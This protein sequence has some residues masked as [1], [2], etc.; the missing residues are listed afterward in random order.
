MNPITYINDN[1][2]D[3]LEADN[4]TH[5]HVVMIA[6]KPDIIKQVPVYKALVK[7]GHLALLIHT[8]QHY[9]HN[10]SGGMLEEFG[11][12]PDIHLHVKGSQ[13]EVIA[14]IIE[15]LGDIFSKC[16]ELGKIVIPYVHGD[17]TTAMAS[18]IAG[19]TQGFAA[20]HI[21]A[22]IR[23]LTPKYEQFNVGELY[24]K[25]PQPDIAQW[26]E[27]LQQ[28]GNWSRGSNEPVPEQFNTK[29]AEA[30]SG[31]HLAS[32]PLI[33]EFLEAEGVPSNRIAVV[34][35]SVADATMDAV[36]N[37]A[38]ST[39]FETY[40]QLADGE[41][42]RFCIHR[43]ENCYNEAR[44]R[45]LFDALKL[46]VKQGRTVLLINM[47]Q[48]KLAF[49]RY[50]LLNELEKLDKEHDNFILS[51]VWP[52]YSDVMAA[53]QRAA[54]CAT[55]SGSMQE[56]MNVLGIPCVT[57]R[58]GSDRSEAAMVGGNLIAPPINAQFIADCITYAWDNKE[59]RN[60]EKI[61]GTNVSEKCIEF[62]ETVLKS[63][64]VFAS[65]EKR[66]GFA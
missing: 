13:H 11:V 7:R 64:E 60:A 45:V 17:T 4:R 14:Q 3:D 30:V 48:T 42:V 65:E 25:N 38:N 47:I 10:L 21:E 66:L 34:G 26:H 2:F 9:D 41:F 52:L 37:A 49:E 6:T 28:R 8:G 29:A 24:N 19:Y 58:F 15:R 32:V 35:N 39:I 12:Q 1:F 40:P 53:M 54:V 16:K 20:V 33:Q 61:Y 55:D 22:G 5:V 23:T 57:L 50:G 18:G 31:V 46:I 27:F 44:F 62:V 36:A 59:M 56:E 51:E 63:D 43:R